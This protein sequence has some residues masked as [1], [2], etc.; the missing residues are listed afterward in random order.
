MARSTQSGRGTRKASGD[1]AEGDVAG[2]REKGVA[3][4]VAEAAHDGEEDEREVD[5]ADVAVVGERVQQRQME[6]ASV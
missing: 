5:E 1:V 2:R 3:E 4:P 6:H